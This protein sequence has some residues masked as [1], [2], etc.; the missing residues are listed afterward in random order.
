MQSEIGALYAGLEKD[1]RFVSKRKDNNC[2]QICVNLG[3]L[4]TGQLMMFINTTYEETK[5]TGNAYDDG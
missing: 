4:V 2:G 5:Q 3:K 1:S